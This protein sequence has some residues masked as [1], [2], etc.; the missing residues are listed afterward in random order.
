MNSGKSKV[1]LV[2]GASENP[3]RYSN[4]A[5]QLLKSEGFSV[6]ALG[7]RT[8]EISGTPIQTKSI[9]EN[10]SQ[11]DTITLYINPKIQTE[12]Y[13]FIIELNPK[14]VLFNPGTENKDLQV[15]LTENKIEWE[16]A[17]TLILLRSKQ[18]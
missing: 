3:A 2:I 7:K 13:D 1:T 6:E 8:G 17:C 18:Y 15:K 16:E 10:F 11:I 14:R 12:Y 4:M 9:C 5:I